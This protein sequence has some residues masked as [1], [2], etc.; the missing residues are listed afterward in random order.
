[1]FQIFPDGTFLADLMYEKE[2]PV[3]VLLGMALMSLKGKK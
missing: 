1:M 3:L 2:I